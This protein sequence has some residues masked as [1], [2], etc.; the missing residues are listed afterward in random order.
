[1]KSQ[2]QSVLD[3]IMVVKG[4]LSKNLTKEE[5]KQV[6]EIILSEIE[7]GECRF[8][9]FDKYNTLE[10]RFSY[11]KGMVS[12][13]L[14]KSKELNNGEKYTPTY[15]KGPQKSETLKALELLSEKYPDNEEVQTALK[16]QQAKESESKV[17]KPSIN[18]EALPEHLRKF[19]S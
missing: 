2:K 16:A 7:S 14:R 8:D 3:S 6:S 5:I 18:V 10:L 19:V 11:V 13:W 9:S 12:N 15:R 4:E 17:K 1:M